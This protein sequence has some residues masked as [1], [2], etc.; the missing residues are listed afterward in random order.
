[1]VFTEVDEMVSQKS[2]PY[3]YFSP[4]SFSIFF[5]NFFSLATLDKNVPEIGNCEIEMQSKIKTDCFNDRFLLQ[6]AF[7]KN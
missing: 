6:K 5:Q 4:D 1:M 3:N 2:H 7:L